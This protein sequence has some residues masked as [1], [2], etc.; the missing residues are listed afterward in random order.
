[1]PDAAGYRYAEL[2]LHLGG[3]ILP[4]VLWSYLQ[5]ER[6]EDPQGDFARE[7]QGVV[8]EF[9]EYADFERFLTRDCATLTEY[10]EAHKRV[11][12][13]RRSR[14]CLTTSIA[15][16]GGRRCSRTSRIWSFGTT[17]TSASRATRRRG[18]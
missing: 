7:S 14:A 8:D 16:C 2:H 5:R 3:A 17:R 15:S 12:P 6:T 10:L 1:M 9:G 18:G 4:R 13:S 11:E